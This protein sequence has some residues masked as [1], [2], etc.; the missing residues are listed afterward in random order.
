MEKVDHVKVYEVYEK[1]GF[2][3]FKYVSLTGED[4]EL[5][6]VRDMRE[7][8]DTRSAEEKLNDLGIETRDRGY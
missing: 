7:K 6:S 3:L 2:Y 5:Y 8:K 4:Y 1:V